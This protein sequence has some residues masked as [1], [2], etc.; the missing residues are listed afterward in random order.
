MYER[1]SKMKKLSINIL[2]PLGIYA[3]AMRRCGVYCIAR[4]MDKAGLDIS[5]ALRA[6][7]MIR[8]V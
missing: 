6:M 7:R 8:S 5:L 1:G 3:H 4:H 2:Q